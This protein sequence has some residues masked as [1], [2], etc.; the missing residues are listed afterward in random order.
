M[1][2]A[3]GDQPIGKRINHG[4]CI[5]RSFIFGPFFNLQTQHGYFRQTNGSTHPLDRVGRHAHHFGIIV[6]DPFLQFRSQ[7]PKFLDKHLDQ[8]VIHLVGRNDEVLRVLGELGVILLLLDVGLE[9]DIGEL[10]KVGRASL[11]VATIGVI[12]P[13]LLS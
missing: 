5:L 1:Y 7:P 6:P 4:A 11:S 10:R 8:L 9:M 2:L 13:M 12:A 3:E